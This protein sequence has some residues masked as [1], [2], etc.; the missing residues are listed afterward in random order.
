MRIRQATIVLIVATVLGLAMGLAAIAYANVAY[1]TR[2]G[3][4]VGIRDYHDGHQDV[5]E[6]VV[7]E[8][9]TLS[10]ITIKAPLLKDEV[11]DDD[12]FRT[13]AH[14]TMCNLLF[15]ALLAG[16]FNIVVGQSPD[17]SGAPFTSYLALLRP[18]FDIEKGASDRSPQANYSYMGRVK[19]I[20]LFSPQEGDQT[21]RLCRTYIGDQD[22]PADV[23]V[24]Q[25]SKPRTYFALHES[26]D[27][28][29]KGLL[30]SETTTVK[31]RTRRVGAEREVQLEVIVGRTPPVPIHRLL[32]DRIIGWFKRD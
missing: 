10:T 12:M 1:T 2:R 17:S 26:C 31:Q 30:S 28:L 16:E 32:M 11:T 9:N 5:C 24:V 23:L 8:R 19:G 25:S 18:D 15:Q 29:A 22:R 3:K 20:E 6:A 4:I 14:I 13:C 21:G 7:R 27:A